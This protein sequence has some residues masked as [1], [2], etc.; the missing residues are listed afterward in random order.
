[1][2]VLDALV[3]VR[4]F[5]MCFIHVRVRGVSTSSSFPPVNLPSPNPLPPKPFII[6]ETTKKAVLWYLICP[7][8]KRHPLK[9]EQYR[10]PLQLE[11]NKQSSPK[12]PKE[13]PQPNPTEY[14]NR[15]IIIPSPKIHN[16]TRTRHQPG[17]ST[18]YPQCPSTTN[19]S[20][21]IIPAK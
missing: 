10:V 19:H 1:M 11:A 8:S 21:R 17:P 3:N 4:Y 14:R 7:Q 13:S 16:L 6:H 12:D 20:L 2:K 9:T 18:Q 15:K 5:I